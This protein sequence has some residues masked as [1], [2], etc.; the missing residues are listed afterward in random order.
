MVLIGRTPAEE[1]RSRAHLLASTA[2][3]SISKPETA[4]ENEVGLNNV[5]RMLQGYRAGTLKIG[6]SAK[7][8]SALES[9]TQ[10]IFPNQ[11]RDQAIEKV[12]DVIRGMVYPR[13]FKQPSEE[14]REKA[15]YFFEE[16]SEKLL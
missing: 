12:E 8:Y 3:R 7:V 14:D 9:A 10:S 6:V 5:Y 2:L 4:P 1:A 16:L 11:S 15:K 13:E